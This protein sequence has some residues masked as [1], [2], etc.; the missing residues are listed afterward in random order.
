MSNDLFVYPKKIPKHIKKIAMY[1]TYKHRTFS[2]REKSAVKQFESRIKQ[3]S[4]LFKAR[5][6]PIDSGDL[7][8]FREKDYTL[9]IY[10]ASD[11]LWWTHNELAYREKAPRGA[12]LPD[13]KQAYKIAEEY[14]RKYDLVNEYS[15]FSSV[16]YTEAAYSSS[17]KENP[18]SA[19]TEAHV[20]YKFSLDRIPVLGPGAKI[21]VS[22]VE[23]STMSELLYFW[24]EPIKEKSNEII[25]PEEALKKITND[26]RFMRLSSKTAVVNLHKMQLGYF[27]LTPSDFQRYLI[28]VYA[29]DGTAKTKDF[30]RYDFT[31]YVVA[32]PL[33]P[34]SI[35]EAGI[36]ADPNSCQVF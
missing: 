18:I 5:S 1:R 36:V 10:R 31:L 26:P 7:M 9:E 27:A 21:Q 16:D 2:R 34:T 35:K 20:N 14:L 30:E 33:T 15:K 17:P 19:K 13:E 29:V 12:K 8:L 22:L 3:F 11:S 32:A 4:G 25:H 6:E 28:P 24:R 23:N